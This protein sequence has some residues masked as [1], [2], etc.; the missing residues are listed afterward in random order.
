MPFYD[1][2]NVETEYGSPDAPRVTMRVGAPVVSNAGPAAPPSGDVTL[3]STYEGIQARL[4]EIRAAVDAD[5]RHPLRDF[6]HP[7]YARVEAE[8]LALHAA[9]KS[10][11]VPKKAP[12]AAEGPALT[13]EEG[14][15]QPAPAE[16]IELERAATPDGYTADDATQDA[17]HAMGEGFG[18]GA[19]ANQLTDELSRC[20]TS[21]PP[22]ARDELI[23]QLHR[24]WPGTTFDDNVDKVDFIEWAAQSLTTTP[25]VREKIPAYLAQLMGYRSGAHAVVRIYDQLHAHGDP[26]QLEQ[27]H[28]AWG[29]AQDDAA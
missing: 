11:V 23:A 3:P 5:P 19:E 6:E 28:L 10:G 14:T 26:A 17:V 8:W 21:G 25:A 24:D 1:K 9:A 16:P 18:L 27:L 12:A 29:A 7:D 15:N 22:P 13:F 4:D 20:L 2:D